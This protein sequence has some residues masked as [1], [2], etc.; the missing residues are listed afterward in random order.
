MRLARLTAA[1]VVLG[2]GAVLAQGGPAVKR[3]EEEILSA[4]SA[5]QALEARCARLGLAASPRV[6]ALRDRG[7][8]LQADREVRRLLRVS[9]GETVRYRR[10]RL[11]CGGQVLSEA[12]NWYVPSRLTPA[13][14]RAL[15]S[16]DTS[17]GTVVKP[18]RFRRQ[19]LRVEQVKDRGRLFRV[20]ALL[21]DS[22]GRPFSLVQENYS[23]ALLGPR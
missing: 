11:A 2:S 7:V 13:M 20:V 5:T 9:E 15:D 16:S 3:L 22:R 8:Q 10:V 6:R 1:L 19:T 4:P 21:V 23:R 12:D 14:N 18:L 17:F